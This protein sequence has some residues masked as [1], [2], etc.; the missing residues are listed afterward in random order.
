MF[1]CWYRFSC[2]FE[3]SLGSGLV[4]VSYLLVILLGVWSGVILLTMC[5]MWGCGVGLTKVVLA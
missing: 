3:G 1:L 2:I 5:C 4:L